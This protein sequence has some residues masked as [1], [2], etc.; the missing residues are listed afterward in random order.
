MVNNYD[1]MV[2]IMY[3]NK[4]VIRKYQ[5][6]KLQTKVMFVWFNFQEDW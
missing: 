6:S 2:I 1:Y 4:Q 5:L 3:T